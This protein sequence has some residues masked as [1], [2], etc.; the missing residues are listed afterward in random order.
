MHDSTM[1]ATQLSY[2]ICRKVATSEGMVDMHE[3]VLEMINAVDMAGNNS[4]GYREF[5]A[6]M[7]E[8]VMQGSDTTQCA[9]RPILTNGL[10]SMLGGVPH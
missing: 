10:T 9:V 4:I 6:A 2:S 3:E 8:K 5:L 1:R 7:M